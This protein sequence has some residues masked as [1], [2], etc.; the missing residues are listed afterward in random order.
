MTNLPA[1]SSQVCVVDHLPV[2]ATEEYDGNTV[3][4]PELTDLAYVIYTSGTTGTPK[5]V[6]VTHG[7][8]AN[9]FSD[10]AQRVALLNAAVGLRLLLFRSI[11]QPSSSYCLFVTGAR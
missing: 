7:A 6:A 11:L 5:G 9:V 2:T 1:V 4:I 3:Y 8:L 10:V